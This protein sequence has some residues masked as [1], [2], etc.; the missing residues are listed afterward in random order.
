MAVTTS[1]YLVSYI[2]SS[3]WVCVIVWCVRSCNSHHAVEVFMCMM[4]LLNSEL[5]KL[6][7]KYW[8]SIAS[9]NPELLND[10]EMILCI[11]GYK[12]LYTSA[13]YLSPCILMIIYQIL[14]L[15]LIFI[16]DLPEFIKYSTI[17]LFADDLKCI[18]YWLVSSLNDPLLQISIPIHTW[19]SRH[20]ANEH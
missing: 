15:F 2:N 10:A 14:L 6:R 4:S 1:I 3:W 20:L 13:Y 7:V 11:T 16:D 8:T 17:W 9:Y 5:A 12:D 18:L 19:A